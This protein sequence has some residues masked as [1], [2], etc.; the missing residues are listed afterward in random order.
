MRPISTKLF[1]FLFLA[2]SFLS[3]LSSICAQQPSFNQIIYVNFGAVGNNDG[4]SWANAYTDL[5]TAIDAI[6]QK[7]T[8]VF[9]GGGTY[10]PSDSSNPLQNASFSFNYDSTYVYGG[11]TGTEDN[12]NDRLIAFSPISVTRLS[13]DNGDNDDGRPDNLTV[14][15]NAYNVVIVNSPFILF[16]QVTIS[17][18]GAVGNTVETSH[19]AAMR[20]TPSNKGIHLIDCRIVDNFAITAGAGIFRTMTSNGNEMFIDRCLFQNNLARYGSGIYMF[21]NNT[22]YGV[23]ILN[24]V[25][26]GNIATD[27]GANIPGI[28]GSSVWLRAT[29]SS[30]ANVAIINNTFYSNEDSG[31]WSSFQNIEYGTVGLS[32][33][34]GGNMTATLANNLF[35]ANMA[36]QGATLFTY[37][38]LSE[39]LQDGT[40]TVLNNVFP[41]ADGTNGNFFHNPNLVDIF[42]NNFSPIAGDDLIDSGNNDYLLGSTLDYK[43]ETRLYNGTID[44]GAFEYNN[45][46]PTNGVDIVS[47]CD[48][49]TWIDGN[50]Y[51][52]SNNTA[53]EIVA[54]TTGCDSTV[55]LNLTINATPEPVILLNGETFTAGN[56]DASSYQWLDCDNNFAPIAGA[57]GQFFSPGSS[58][59]YAVEITQNGC[60]AISDC[61][62]LSITNVVETNVETELQAFPNPT[63]GDFSVDFGVVHH[64]LEATLFDL[65]GKLLRRISLSQAQLIRMSITEPK[66]VY[67]LKIK[68]E[69]QSALIRLVKN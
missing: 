40:L 52:I 30:Q 23:G 17:N 69:E 6:S 13:G 58:G 11:F 3:P 59:N 32:Q 38:R 47:A 60:L 34:E 50:T 67:L 36:P 31:T 66:G 41:F 21:S 65:H 2:I 49:Y 44:I 14:A 35:M 37:G 57:N 48:S 55:Y 9:I 12:I 5:Q 26:R 39:A 19:G 53:T 1:Y 63:M 33:S 27:L 25:F 28:A 54:T 20:I 68:S 51:T 45:C 15:D 61:K 8:A 10:T 18:G 24:S 22:E 56:P 29:A 16:D 62:N 7:R 4:T 64:D 42:T 43:G 46:M